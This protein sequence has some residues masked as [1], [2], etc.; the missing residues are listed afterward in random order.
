[1][2]DNALTLLAWAATPVLAVL[3]PLLAFGPP[4]A[5]ELVRV[6]RGR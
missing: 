5:V 6:L 2:R 1:M 3:M 4:L